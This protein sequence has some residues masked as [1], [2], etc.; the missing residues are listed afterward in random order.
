MSAKDPFIDMHGQL[1]SSFVE[2]LGPRVKLV[3]GQQ[4]SIKTLI[5]RTDFAASGA[6][7]PTQS[8]RDEAEKACDISATIRARVIRLSLFRCF[9]DASRLP[10]SPP[11]SP[12]G[13]APS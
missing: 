12:L 3:V 2:R 10:P 5:C 11:I 6:A 1:T 4:L 8:P 7:R 9:V 13:T